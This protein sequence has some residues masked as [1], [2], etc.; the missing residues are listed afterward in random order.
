MRSR[1]RG[2]AGEDAGGVGFRVRGV[3]AGRV[4]VSSVQAV[5]LEGAED[6][7]PRTVVEV[8]EECGVFNAEAE[9]GV[10]AVDGRARGVPLATAVC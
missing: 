10:R 1:S 9:R 4:V 5:C 3:L 6:D 8:V 2:D 7:I